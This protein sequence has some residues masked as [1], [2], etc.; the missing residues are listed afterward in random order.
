MKRIVVIA[1]TGWSIH[2]VH[3]GVAAALAGEYTFTYFECRQFILQQFLAAFRS[4]DLCMTTMNFYADM[5]RLFPS[6]TDRQKIVIVAHGISE[7]WGIPSAACTSFTYG[8]T[9]AAVAASLQAKIGQPVFAVPNGVDPAVFVHRERTGTVQRLGWCGA[10]T[11]AV[12]RVDWAHGIAAAT[13]LPLD[14]AATIPRADMATWYDSI[15]LLLMTSGPH[16]TDETGPL[17]AFEA[18][19]AG[20]PVIGSACGNFALLPGPKFATVEEGVALIRELQADPARLREV[21][22][23]QYDCVMAEWT[24]A[25]LSDKWRSLFEAAYDHTLSLKKQRHNLTNLGHYV[26]P[27][28]VR[29]CLCVDIGG[30]TGAFTLKYKDFFSKI[31]VYEPQT[32]CYDI[33][34]DRIKGATNIILYKEAVYRSSGSEFRMVSH[35]NHHSGSVALDTDAIAEKEWTNEVVEAAVTTI[36]LEDVLARAGG[37]VDYLKIDCETGEYNFLIGKDLSA[38]R[39]MG[40]ELSWQIGAERWSELITHLL[41]YFKLVEGSITYTAGCNKECFFERQTELAAEEITAV[42]NVYKRP[43]TLAEQVAAL[44]A[45]TVP[46][47]AIFIWNNGN[48]SVDLSPYKAD[49]LFRVFDS[50]KNMGVWSRF[51]AASMAPTEHIC[52]FDDDTIP[53]P[54]WFE[55]CVAQ[56]KQR[57]ALYG[58]IGVVFKRPDTYYELIVRYGWDGPCMEAKAVDI[59]GHAWF[60]KRDWFKYY[61]AEEPQVH[62]R[63]RNGEDIHFSH[64]LQ[65]YANIP[66]Y[67]PPHPPTDRSLWGSMPKTA[68][69]YG[70]DGNSE[71]FSAEYGSIHAAFQHNVAGGFRL[72]KHR[73]HATSV[74]DLDYYLKMIMERKPFA[75]VRPGDGEYIVMQNQTIKVLDKWT[76]T[77]GGGL[78]TALT[79]ALELASKTGCHIGIPC[80]CCNAKM[81]VWYR[82]R[83]C[84]PYPW[85]TFANIFVNRN[86]RP[87]IQFLQ[88]N[89]IGFTLIG[90]AYREGHF[91]VEQFIQVP[92][93]LVNDW[94]TQGDEYVSRIVDVV[95]KTRGKIYM[96][97]CGPIAKIMVA[98]AWAVHPHNLYLDIGSSLDSFMKGSET[99]TY[100]VEGSDYSK[101]VCKFTPEFLPA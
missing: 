24:Y 12:K 66:T 92:E 4:A 16:V 50:D 49:P 20:V 47:K 9:S 58:T 82:D 29:G 70:G 19:V 77:A 86:W 100:M 64:M 45:Q 25:A 51:I 98:R 84:V 55:N 91:A 83:F 34:A 80:T 23:E 75:I 79:E 89:R 5:L 17:P 28:T 97:S 18:I 7:T 21:A 30:N 40:I 96:F 60:F 39:Y 56:M 41:K 8:A 88:N 26:V 42:L 62:T 90:P 22:K 53:G 74:G 27:E 35:S 68:F 101:L 85:L 67:V 14:I 13:G 1:D 54:R 44:R 61:F 48:K 95:Q 63:S 52:V 33:I 99:R 71:T 6:A 69:G 36:S 76:F 59:V 46:P 94:D 78:A 87:W 65:K 3:Q 31:H 72:I 10:P 38:I 73:Q 43:H 37:S 57:V 81:S 11:V 93:F 2:R 15:D 32:E